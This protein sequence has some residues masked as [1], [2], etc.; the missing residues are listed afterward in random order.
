MYVLVY[1]GRLGEY[2]K[3]NFRESSLLGIFSELYI[4]IHLCKIFTLNIPFYL[5]SLILA[6]I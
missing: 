1:I 6:S 4:Y 2:G 3:L 5:I